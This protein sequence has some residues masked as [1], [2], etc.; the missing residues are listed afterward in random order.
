MISS[1]FATT[2]LNRLGGL[3]F[4]P[5]PKKGDSIAQ[6]AFKEL[7]LALEC[8]A[9]DSIAKIVVDDWL[10]NNADAP[11][12]AELRKMAYDENERLERAE[13]DKYRP[14]PPRAAHCYLCQDFG[15]VESVDAGDVRSIACYCDCARGRE[16]L[17]EAHGPEERCTPPRNPCPDCV[18]AARRKLIAIRNR[19]R[20]EPPKEP[21]MRHVAEVYHGE[22]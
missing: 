18:N 16:R 19:G 4:F 5:T 9:S 6:A 2:Q 13:R 1:E 11:K 17:A 14:P 8:A 10:N 22:F 12:P 7:R 21:A 15:I 20:V 3:N